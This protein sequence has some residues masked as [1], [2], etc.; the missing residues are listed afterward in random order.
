MEF[1]AQSEGGHQPVLLDEV[2]QRMEP[3]AGE[4]YVDAT[5]GGGDIPV[6]F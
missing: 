1:C 6:H 3:K 4:R 5:F 2:I